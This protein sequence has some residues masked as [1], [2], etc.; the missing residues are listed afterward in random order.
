MTLEEVSALATR[1]KGEIDQAI[2]GPIDPE[3]YC[4]RAYFPDQDDASKFYSVMRQDDSAHVRVPR[5]RPR[6][7]TVDL[8][9]E[10]ED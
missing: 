9:F 2:S 8:T 10:P 7:W 3:T 5:G 6:V 1:H 4:M